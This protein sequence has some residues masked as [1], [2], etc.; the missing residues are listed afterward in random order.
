MTCIQFFQVGKILQAHLESVPL[1]HLSPT[2]VSFSYPMS[3]TDIIY[4]IKPKN[5]FLLY[6]Y[7]EKISLRS[8]NYY[9]DRYEMVSVFIEAILDPGTTR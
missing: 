6:C 4:I 5:S 8:S 2:S 7:S 1:G 3:N 9:S